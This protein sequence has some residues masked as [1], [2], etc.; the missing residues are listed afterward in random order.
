MC[1]CQASERTSCSHSPTQ[2]LLAL[3]A[4]QRGANLAQSVHLVVHCAAVITKRRE[5]VIW[6][7]SRLR[8]LNCASVSWP[9]T[10]S[11]VDICTLCGSGGGIIFNNAKLIQ[12]AQNVTITMRINDCLG[13]HYCTFVLKTSA[14]RSSGQSIASRIKNLS[15]WNPPMGSHLFQAGGLIA[16]QLLNVPH[17][18]SS[19]QLI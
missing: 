9:Q 5:V 4:Q 14:D 7:S 11:V 1:L 2:L 16:V 10:C 15:P 19:L 17:I 8:C 13:N 18:S 6:E 3:Q 12:V